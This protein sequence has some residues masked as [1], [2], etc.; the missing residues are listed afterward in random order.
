MF[1]LSHADRGPGLRTQT[2]ISIAPAIESVPHHRDVWG[3]CP[4]GQPQD[5]G[6][7][8]FSLAA[9]S[10]LDP[11]FPHPHSTIRLH[12][13]HKRNAIAD[14]E[15]HFVL[16]ISDMHEGECGNCHRVQGSHNKIRSNSRRANRRAGGHFGAV[17][18]L[19]V[20]VVKG[21]LVSARW[22]PSVSDKFGPERHHH[23]PA[24]AATNGSYYGGS[25]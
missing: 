14:R 1:F 18:G 22:R 12:L 3:E 5:P 15:R 21:G 17:V 20:V 16:A 6:N 23:H 13:S 24:S 10:P 11:H 9:T 8:S 7:H 19:G 25:L 4:G 2:T